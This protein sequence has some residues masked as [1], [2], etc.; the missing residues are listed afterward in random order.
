M[1]TL[2]ALLPLLGET[3]IK[4][5]YE[6]Q[7]GVNREQ[8]GRQQA[9]TGLIELQ[10]LKESQAAE[11]E[12]M[13]AIQT[14]PALAQQLF[15]TIATLPTTGGPPAG[16]GAITQ[17][18]LGGGPAQQ[19]PAYPDASRYAQVPS[20]SGGPIPPNVMG[21]VMPQV[22]SPQSTLASLGP[23]PQAG[24]QNPV[25]EM[26][27]TNPRAA[28]MLS[29]QLQGQQ[30]AALKRQ[31]Q[32][33]TMGTK[34][35]EYL[36]RGAQ[37]VTDQASLDAFRQEVARVHPQAA[38][39]LPQVYSKEA[40]APFIAKALDVKEAMTLQVQDLQAQ[41]AVMKARREQANIPN[42]T[43]DAQLD[44]LIYT[45][46]KDHP[47]GTMPSQDIVDA[48][49][50][51][52]EKNKLN[53]SERQGIQAA[54]IERTEKPLEG[55]AGKAVSDLTTLRRLSDD[56]AALRKDDFTGPIVG[57]TG[58]LREQAGRMDQQETAFRTTIKNMTDILARLR[59]GAAIP[60]DDMA[61]LEQLVPSVNDHPETFKA[62][63]QSFQR[64]V[65]QQRETRLQ[66]GTTGRQRLRE[67][68]TPTTPRVGEQP[69]G[70]AHT[71]GPATFDR[72]DFLRWRQGT[73]KTGNP[74][75]AD[76]EAYFQAKGLTRR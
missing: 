34:V 29:Q 59:S 63:L 64:A 61:R 57:R 73:G 31:E 18:P 11:A 74:T 43:G 37:G 1:S 62:K 12:L 21:Q 48:A 46:M 67:E 53:V 26:A 25:L 38:A 36:G 2:A 76:V 66:V 55:E 56:V 23:R 71:Q 35:M 14:N 15:G 16:A 4:P 58:Y 47:P 8:I 49:I 70:Q 51:Q 20:T 60:P 75:Q 10:R 33:L 24:S 30:D 52:R 65:E 72:A 28:M 50:Q 54:E 9:Q 41:A 68:T 32:Q 44:A 5:W 13:Q 19:I 40:M 3:G 42:Y 45:K 39:Q 7:Q 6:G 22:T 17:S 27:R 69:Q